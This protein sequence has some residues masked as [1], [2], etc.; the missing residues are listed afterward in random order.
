MKENEDVG[1]QIKCY[2]AKKIQHIQLST[3]VQKVRIEGSVSD[4]IQVMWRDTALRKLHLGQKEDTLFLR[5]E[6]VPFLYGALGLIELTK[7]ND[8]LLKIP[9]QYAGTVSIH[10]TTN[11]ISVVDCR[12]NGKLEIQTNTGAISVSGT[13]ADHVSLNA[14]HGVITCEHIKAKQSLHMETI[15]GFIECYLDRE[16]QNYVFDCHSKH[17]S[18]H[19][20]SANLD[21]NIQ[22]E[23]C[24]VTA[25]S[26]N[27]S[28]HVRY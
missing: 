8:L 23:P 9:F 27:G 28:I 22:Y 18:C 12:L 26:V 24:I 11:K 15:T 16:N 1:R 7:G 4:E 13:L 14:S 2:A 17:G 25:Q 19:F 20:P 6:A 5:D 3:K 10:T 21:D